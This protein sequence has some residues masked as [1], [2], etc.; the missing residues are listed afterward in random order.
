MSFVCSGVSGISELAGEDCP[1][2]GCGGALDAD[3]ELAEAMA[4]FPCSCFLTLFLS[5]L[6]EHLDGQILELLLEAGGVKA[7]V[8]KSQVDLS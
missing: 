7:D 1:C 2:T 8:F 4:S 6:L 5:E 3:A